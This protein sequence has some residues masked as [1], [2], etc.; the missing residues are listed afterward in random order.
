MTCLNASPPFHT[1]AS[2]IPQAFRDGIPTFPALAE[3]EYE[4]DISC[5]PHEEP[6]DTADVFHICTKVMKL[7]TG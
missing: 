1:T 7:I 3:Y 2:T 4:S 5:T 6:H